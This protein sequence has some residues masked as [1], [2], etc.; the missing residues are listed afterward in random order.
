M[1]SYST[2]SPSTFVLNSK[3]NG[4]S[5]PSTSQINSSSKNPPYLGLTENL[6]GR[7]VLGLRIPFY[8]SNDAIYL[9]DSGTFQ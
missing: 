9:F 6:I 1:S 7:L 5:S 4:I 8:G 2:E 3:P